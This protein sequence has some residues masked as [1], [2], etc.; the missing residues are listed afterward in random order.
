MA[1]RN[2]NMTVLQLLP[3][4]NVGGVERGTIEIATALVNAGHRGLVISNH[5][6]LVAELEAAGAVHYDLPIG[7]KSLATLG[8]VRKVRRIM[9]EQKVDIVHAR[10]RLPAWIGRFALR[11]IP[12]SKRPRWITTVH[13]PYS[14]NRYS[15]VMASGEKVIAISEFIRD[16]VLNNYPR[17]NAEKLTVVH[18]GVDIERYTPSFKPS[19][20]WMKEFQ[21]ADF[22]DPDKKILIFPGRLTRWK[23]QADFL[24]LVGSLISTGQK[25]C[26]LIVGAQSDAKSQFERE[27]K[28]DVSKRG[29]E[30]HIHFLG[31][32][33]DLRELFSQADISYSLPNVPEAFG[34]TTLEALSLGTPVIGYD[35]GGTGEILRHL[36]PAGLVAPGNVNEVAAKTRQFLTSEPAVPENHTMTSQNMQRETLA[37]YQSM[38]N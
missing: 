22:Y 25:V 28:Q 13:G 31:E 5:G 20:S 21:G 10:S 34:R 3:D 8:L 24:A 23:G 11:G 9:L 6:R 18:R 1:N 15:E 27:L 7:R 30:E 37:A 12:P 26:G 29:L 14:V 38:L 35:N 2:K 17:V 4:L 16:Y 32:R 33:H 19:T 36:F